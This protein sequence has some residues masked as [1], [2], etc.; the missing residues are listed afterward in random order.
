M[1]DQHDDN[2][3]CLATSLSP[4]QAH[5]WQN[6][7]EDEGI[8]AQVVGDFLEAGLGN[9][10]GLGAELWVHADDV[11]RA[12]ELLMQHHDFAAGAGTDEEEDEEDDEGKEEGEPI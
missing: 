10:P 3:V 6:A 8:R 1:H 4:A 11:E 12:K 9:I 2:I 7:L 5:I